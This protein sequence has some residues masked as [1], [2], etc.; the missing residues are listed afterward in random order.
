MVGGRG[1]CHCLSGQGIKQ[2][3]G[4]KDR[5][6]HKNRAE[7]R[8]LRALIHAE[9]GEAGVPDSGDLCVYISE[10]QLDIVPKP[11]LNPISAA[12]LTSVGL[13]V[14]ESCA[15]PQA[16]QKVQDILTMPLLLTVG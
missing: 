1:K 16:Q 9:L 15:D 4:Y 6:G 14:S 11:T 5:A 2:W 12:G 13:S 3:A 8:G 10:Q 7:S